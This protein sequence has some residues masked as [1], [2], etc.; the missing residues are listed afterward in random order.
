MEAHTLAVRIA[1]AMILKEIRQSLG[2]NGIA[3][4]ASPVDPIFALRYE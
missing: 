4:R 1:I 3:R 2:G